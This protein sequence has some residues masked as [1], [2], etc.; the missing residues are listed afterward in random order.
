MNKLKK[1]ENKKD[2]KLEESGSSLVDDHE[3]DCNRKR[4]KDEDI[5]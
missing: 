2:V 4:I 5:V 3:Q 1:E